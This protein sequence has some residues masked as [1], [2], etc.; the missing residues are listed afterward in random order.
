[1][2]YAAW[3]HN[4]GTRGAFASWRKRIIVADTAEQIWE[5][6]TGAAE[7][8]LLDTIDIDVW[9]A[10]ASGSLDVPPRSAVPTQEEL[11]ADSRWQPIDPNGKSLP[12]RTPGPDLGD[13]PDGDVE[14]YDGA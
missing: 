14:G 4:V 3:L 13:D 8:V 7:A 12:P 10:Q 5:V 2:K 11:K 6:F 1:M 9:R